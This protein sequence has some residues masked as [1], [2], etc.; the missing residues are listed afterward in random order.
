V[1]TVPVGGPAAAPPPSDAL[2]GFTAPSPPAVVELAPLPALRSGLTMLSY[3]RLAHDANLAAIT[4]HPG[5][6]LAIDPAEFDVDDS[7]GEVGADDLP[8]GASS[9][10]LLHD[11]LEVADLAFARTAPDLAAW[12]SDPA[13]AAQIADKARARGIAERYLPHA[14]AIVHRTLTQPLA[15]VDGSTLPPLMEAIAFAREVEFGYPIPAIADAAG[16]AAPVRG[17]VKGFIDGLIAWDDELWVLDYKSDLLVGE[18]LGAAAQRRVRERYAV[19]ARLYA[20]A[21]DRLRGRRRLAGLLFAFVRHDVTVPV[22]IAEDTLAGW[23]DW[24]A[25]IAAYEPEVRA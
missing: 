22:R 12:A 13:V 10:L 8:P 17:L 20:I 3:T 16:A 11:V 2:A 4:A 21:A 18:D 14:A 19:Q 24:L 6:A 25:R 5:D 15:L 9:G 1:I 7:A 23:T